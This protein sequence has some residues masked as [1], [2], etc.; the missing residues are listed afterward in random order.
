L[1]TVF[2]KVLSSSMVQPPRLCRMLVFIASRSKCPV[3]LRAT[4]QPPQSSPD[5]SPG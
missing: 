4:P 3:T 1:L 5:R 2:S